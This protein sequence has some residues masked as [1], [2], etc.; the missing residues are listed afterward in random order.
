[1]PLQ[2]TQRIRAAGCSLR[3]NDYR[4]S[5]GLALVC[6]ALWEVV[7]DHGGITETDIH[8][9]IKEIE[10]R[11][12]RRDGRMTG[13]TRMSVCMY[14]GTPFEGCKGPVAPG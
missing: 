11:D 6:E 4:R 9:K 14:C 10:L 7:R 5:D 3:C 12:G 8:D 2:G 13:H 1:M